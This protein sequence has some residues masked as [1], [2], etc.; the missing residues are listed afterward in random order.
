M[1][2]LKELDRR[3]DAALAKETKESLNA[4]LSEQRVYDLITIDW[5]P[6][7]EECMLLASEPNGKYMMKD[8]TNLFYSPPMQKRTNKSTKN[9]SAINVESFFFSIIALW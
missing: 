7:S 4:W 2:N 6:C 9:D 5:H 8:Y 3:L 1:I